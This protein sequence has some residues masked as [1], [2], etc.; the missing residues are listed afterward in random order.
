MYRE[1]PINAIWEGSGNVQCLDVLRAMQKDPDVLNAFMN[2]LMKAA[3]HFEAFDIYMAAIK[4]ELSDTS[5]L[6]YRAR[7]VVEKLAVAWQASTLI[8]FGD[9]NV[10]EAYVKSRLTGYSGQYYGTLPTGLN[11]QALIRRS[12]PSN[13]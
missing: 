5:E 7:T 9:K 1:A 4:H 13:K 6:E 11:I 12:T 8:Q 2:E 10:A 3:N